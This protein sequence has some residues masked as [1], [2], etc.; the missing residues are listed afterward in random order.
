M[1]IQDVAIQDETPSNEQWMEVARAWG[2]SCQ[3][4]VRTSTDF[5]TISRDLADRLDAA[6]SPHLDEKVRNDL[7]R[8][9]CRLGAVIEAQV[10]ILRDDYLATAAGLAEL[11]MERPGVKPDGAQMLLDDQ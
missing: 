7:A 9:L 10:Q 3:T 2:E 8:E 4:L 1:L 6:S 11:G 5:S